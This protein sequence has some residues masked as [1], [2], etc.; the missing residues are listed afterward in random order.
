M[1]SRVRIGILIA[2]TA[3]LMLVAASMVGVNVF[4]ILDAMIL[5]SYKDPV[6]FTVMLQKLTVYT[7]AGVA[8]HLALRAGL[9]NIGVEGQFLMG[10]LAASVAALSVPGPVGMVLGALAGATA[11]GFWAWPAGWLKARKGSHE[12][13][14]T[15]MLNAIAANLSFFLIAGVL[16]D[17]KASTAATANLPAETRIPA[18]L[19]SYV[20]MNALV[21]NS[22]LLVAAVVYVVYYR[23]LTRSVKGFEV[24]AVGE[25]P[26]AARF[27][28]VNSPSVVLRAMVSS[29]AIAGFAGSLHLMSA[30]GKFVSSFSDGYGYDSLGV[31][32]LSGGHPAALVPSAVLFATLGAGTP[33][34]QQL[35]V[36][37]GLT[38][39]VLALVI[40]I[41]AAIRATKGAKNV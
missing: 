5:S 41:F 27:A 21:I 23:W 11:G 38:T 13:I 40:V 16:K 24:S 6:R 35:G 31:A 20:G 1:N 10:G 14:S 29:G 36:P 22:A 32:L 7:V 9:F 18:V 37:L 34:V 2:V 15:I 33:K 4:A 30:T 17:P 3:G 26:T 39:V 8:V 25:N 28:G 12:V 19:T